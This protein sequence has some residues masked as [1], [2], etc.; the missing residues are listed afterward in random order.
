M[1][2]TVEKSENRYSLEKNDFL[3]KKTSVKFI[4][5]SVISTIFVFAAS[6]ID[7]LLVGI[8]LGEEGLSAMSLVSPI[9]LIF[10]TVGATVG[11]GASIF[12]SRA[13]GKGDIKEYRRIFT[14][15]TV[16]LAVCSVIMVL[17]S[18][19]FFD[20]IT[21]LLC[22]NVTGK[23]KDLFR[24]YF[25]FYIPG[26]AATLMTYV[27]L[28]F[29]KT[30]GRPKI[31]SRLFT[32][33][34]IMNAGLTA[35]FM[36]PLVNMGIAGAS[37]GTSIAMTTVTI[38][39]FIFTLKGNTELK[40]VRH[41]FDF[42]TLK[43][44]VIS[45]IPNGLNNLLNSV[46]IMF[47]NMMLISI[48]ASAFLS[49]YTVV[50]NVSDLLGSVIVGVSSAIIPLAGI[51]FGERDYEGCRM[52]M[53][54][55]R[56]TGVKIMVPLVL[57]V[58]VLAGPVFRLFAVTEPS[59]IS[60]GRWALPLACVGLIIGY[61]NTLYIGYLTATKHE[62]IATTM[63][64]LR[65]FAVLA[66]F[67]FPLSRLFGSKGIWV[68]FSVS[69]LVTMCV[70]VVI[71]YCIR[72]RKPQIDAFLLD[73]TKEIAN[74]ITFSVKNNPDA[75]VFATTKIGDFCDDNEISPKL[76]MRVSLVIEEILTFLNSHC[77]KDSESY[78]DLRVCKISEEVMVRFRYVGEVYD[79]TAY[80]QRNNDNEELMEE[81]LGL[82]L[83]TKTASLIH[84]TQTMG[85]NNLMFMFEPISPAAAK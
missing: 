47:V 46:R 17:G 26:G 67:A 84:F 72:K 83:V 19:L 11:I 51:L 76:A 20:G 1:K 37:L 61:I 27:P 71:V 82:K 40:F 28:Y 75:I 59:L 24:E 85:A 79:P 64:V 50:R 80:Y 36:S 38:L 48:G 69:E 63:V 62:M 54:Y 68:C 65:L 21:D 7:T 16:V 35:I 25:R 4:I 52:V 43:E 34:G 60:E 39:G 13:L 42:K 12:A 9:Y 55:A 56:K 45:G 81:L 10:Y 2:K 18:Y 41:F 22:M 57:A 70:L 14:S 6:F 49:C 32:L 30:D 73:T 15:A 5:N 23:K 77:L 78:T 74:D 33:S 8:F 29:L 44:T 31:S 66:V 58:S 53:R 3:L